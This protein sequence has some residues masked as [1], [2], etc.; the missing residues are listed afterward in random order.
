MKLASLLKTTIRRKKRLGRGLGSGKGKTAGKGTKGQK[1]RGTIPGAFI[2][3]LPLYK[4]LP[5]RRGLG[6][7][8]L[9][10]KTMVINLSVLEVF[11]AKSVVD[12]EQLI[13]LKIVT[14]KEAKLGV[15]ILGGVI[16]KPLI[17]KLPVSKSVQ[18][19][20]EGQGGRVEN[21]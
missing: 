10:S 16:S 1:V 4:K 14:E 11:P 21:G 3:G 7:P 18:K 19:S 5:L 15:K 12:V 6:N 17:I 13:K 20:I 8:K 2:G 9:T